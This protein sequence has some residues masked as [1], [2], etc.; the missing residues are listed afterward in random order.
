MQS[1]S[2]C[3]CVCTE[4][5][6]PG[7]QCVDIDTLSVSTVNCTCDVS[8][9]GETTTH[10][11]QIYWSNQIPVLSLLSAKINL[12]SVSSFMFWALELDNITIHLLFFTFFNHGIKSGLRWIRLFSGF[13]LLWSLNIRWDATRF[14]ELKAE[15]LTVMILIKPSH[16]QLP[17]NIVLRAPIW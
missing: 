9:G 11:D 2:V 15:T 14:V 13:Q 16:R 17:N 8:W 10:A 5:S 1:Q 4:T 7:R 6:L 3:V 12:F